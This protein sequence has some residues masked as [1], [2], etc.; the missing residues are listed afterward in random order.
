MNKWPDAKTTVPPPH[1]LGWCMNK[2]NEEAK[3][4]KVIDSFLRSY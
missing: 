2:A 3:A 1:I 4:I